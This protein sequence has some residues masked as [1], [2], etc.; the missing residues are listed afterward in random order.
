MTALPYPSTSYHPS[1]SIDLTSKAERE[2]LSPAAL[3]S[4]F[5]LAERWSIRDED[6]RTLLGGI[7]NGP[8][9]EWKKNSERVLDTD[10]LMR[11]SYLVGIFKALHILYPEGLADSWVRLP[12]TNRL[13][14]GKTPL[15]YMSR[16]GIPA[17]HNVRAL[18]DARR[19]GR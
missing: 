8:F 9:Y 13:F 18:L 19:G 6:A 2:R 5:K 1:P 4:F 15:E 16:G 12:N 17:M 11:V 10:R 14:Q 7:T 3:R